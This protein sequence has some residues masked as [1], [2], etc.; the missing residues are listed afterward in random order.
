M[1]RFWET[2]AQRDDIEV[3]AMAHGEAIKGDPE[4][5]KKRFVKLA[6]LF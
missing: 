3:I 4:E 6:S 5:I 1:K 2:L